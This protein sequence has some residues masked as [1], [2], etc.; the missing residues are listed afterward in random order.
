VGGEAAELDAELADALFR[1]LAAAA[2]LARGLLPGV[3]GL[4]HL[5]VAVVLLLEDRGVVLLEVLDAGAVVADRQDPPCREEGDDQRKP[6]ALD[7]VRDRQGAADPASEVSG[8]AV[9]GGGRECV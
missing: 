7:D 4:A 2:F 1:L 5:G 8:C 9:R 6:A 3:P